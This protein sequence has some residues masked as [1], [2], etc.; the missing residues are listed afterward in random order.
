ML[1]NALTRFK[2]Q[3]QPAVAGVALFQ[4]IYHAQ[5]LQIVLKAT[6]I[7]HAGIERILPRMAKWRVAQVM[8]QADGLGQVLVDAQCT[9]NGAPQLR[10]LNRMGEPSAKQI[11]FMVQKNLGLVHQS[12]KRR[13]VHD[14]ITITL[15]LAARRRGILRVNAAFA[16]VRQAGIR[17]KA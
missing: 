17:R 1:Q 8:R 10:H 14:A 2:A 16:L 15:E 5:A 12:A 4:G 9:R 7:L 13:G 6:V 11:A 3:V